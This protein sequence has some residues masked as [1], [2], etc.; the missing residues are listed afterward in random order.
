MRAGLVI[1]VLATYL[2]TQWWLRRRGLPAAV[3]RTRTADCRAAAVADPGSHACGLRLGRVVGRVLAALPSDTRC[4]ARSLVLMRLLAKRGVPASLV[5]G[6]ATEP[7]F[8]AHAWVEHG[9]RPLLPAGEGRF[10]RLLE[11]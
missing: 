3:T 7:E 9:G 1:E 4:L 11:L 6:V 8:S 2:L 10:E 5:I